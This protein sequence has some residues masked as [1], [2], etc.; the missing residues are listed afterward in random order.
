MTE[1]LSIRP[2]KDRDHPALIAL[3][4]D[5]G[6]VRPWN[7]PERD[8]ALCQATPTSAMFVGDIAGALAASIMTGHDG[9]R[10]W[11]YYLAV[12]A[13]HARQGHGRALVRHAEA[14]LA[15]QGVP[16]MLLMIRPS[17]TGVQDFYASLGYKP[18]EIVLMG[19][20]LEKDA[21]WRPAERKTD[22]G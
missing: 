19:R 3:W 22:G 2:Y 4:Q 16:R 9:H 8:I 12:A 7:P 11:I 14:W 13:E 1:P 15:G 20:W 10:G 18:E 5:A 21:A 6:L 17:N